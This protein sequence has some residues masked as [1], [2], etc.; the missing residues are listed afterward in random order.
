MENLIIRKASGLKK[1]FMK[2]LLAVFLAASAIFLFSGSYAPA[3]GAAAP[4]YAADVSRLEA[5]YLVPIGRTAGI[6]IYA[7]GVMVVEFA[8]IKTENGELSPAQECG[9]K[10]GDLI[11]K[12]GKANVESMYELQTEI[13]KYPGKQVS[14]TVLRENKSLNL[15]VIP[16][17][18]TTDSSVKIGAWVR[19]SMAGIGTI[20]FYDPKSGVFGALGHG[21][22]DG[23]TGT[24]MPLA[25]G[26]LIP[27]SVVGINKGENGKPGELI[28]IFET[29]KNCGSLYS[30]CETG[31]YGTLKPDE[32][33]PD[34]L[35]REPIPVGGSDTVSRGSAYILSNIAGENV[36][37]FEIEIIKIINTER[38]TKNLYIRVIDPV[39]LSQTGGIVQGMSGSPIIQN[40]RIIGAVTHVLIN[41]PEYGY[42]ILLENMLENAS[43]R[44]NATAA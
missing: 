26:C 6:K 15:T 41:D 19:D 33:Y 8:A 31:L 25:S 7:G 10:I 11:I 18:D 44:E 21:I 5:K 9:L 40:G 24:L 39:L 35:S 17:V 2:R 3:N 4:A 1:A 43:E 36:E 42:G 29:G 13:S 38:S 30:N 16:R 27:S 37:K 14:L 20:T 12:V 34:L 28:G 32:L 23:D 22:S